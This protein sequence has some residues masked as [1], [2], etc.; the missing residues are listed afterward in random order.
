M[1]IST[2]LNVLDASVSP[3]D[4]VRR[5]VEAGFEALD[6]NYCDYQKVLLTQPWSEEERWAYRFREAADQHG[7]SFSQMHGPIH[8]G[9]FHETMM[10]LNVQ[11]FTALAERALQTAAILGVS[12]VVFHPTNIAFNPAYRPEET[13]DFN[14]QFYSKFLPILEKSG[15]GIA[16]E[17]LFAHRN[18]AWSYLTTSD[19]LVELVDRIGHPLV[20]ACWDTGHGHMSGHDQYDAIKQVGHRLKALHI[21]D[22]DKTLDQHLFPYHGTIDWNKV[23]KAVKE[24][25]YTGDFTYEVHNAVRKVPDQ[26]RDPLLHYAVK[27]AKSLVDM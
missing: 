22:T 26:L 9:S 23:M 21:Q 17:N 27:L 15:V 7:L 13:V 8:G 5:C 2:S 19:E 6:M 16:L 11:S 20:G 25:G 4:Q 12:W 14:V 10:G 3:E 24:I 18:V 1:R